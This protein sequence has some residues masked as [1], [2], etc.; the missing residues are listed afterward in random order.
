MEHKDELREL[1]ASLSGQRL[2][3]WDELPDLELYM[4]Q[5]L[6]LIARYLGG[7]PGF[8][9]KGLT[10]SMVNNYVKLGVM[11]PPVKKKYMRTHLAHLLM[12][13]VLKASLPIELIKGLIGESLD[14]RGESELYD[15]FCEEFEA[16]VK[17]S[18]EAA[19][20]DPALSGIY[21]AALRAQAEQALAVELYEM[22]TGKGE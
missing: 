16:S 3:R 8:D 4:D 12:I 6:S 14:E 1:C 21:R 22:R 7:Y 9:D 5:V 17:A 13:C 19:K 11:P 18:A 15:A 2:P 20:N 10:A